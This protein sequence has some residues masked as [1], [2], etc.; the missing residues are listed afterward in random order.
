MPSSTDAV[1]WSCA[2]CGV[3]VGRIDGEVTEL[4]ESWSRSG[5]TTFCLSCSRARAGEAAIDSAPAASSREERVRLRRT[6]LI[7]FEIDRAPEA[8]NRTIALA[9]RTSS[10]AVA[11]VRENG[12]PQRA[13]LG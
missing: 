11:A 12:E 10:A 13:A 7:E 1:R 3:S 2:R 4:P 6:A 9:C 8:P 5:G